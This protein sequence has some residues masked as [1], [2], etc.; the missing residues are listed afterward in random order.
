MEELEK[1]EMQELKD[2]IYNEVM[3]IKM[4]I[5]ALNNNEIPPCPI[6]KRNL[7]IWL[8]GNEQ[9]TAI[10]NGTIDKI[11]AEIKR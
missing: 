3:T 11:D 7:E 2:N 8:T 4:Y 9:L 10:K 1:L 6:S 5:S